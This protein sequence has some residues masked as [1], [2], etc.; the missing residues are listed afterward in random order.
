MKLLHYTLQWL[1]VKMSQLTLVTQTQAAATFILHSMQP[2]LKTPCVY[3]VGHQYEYDTNTVM[4]LLFHKVLEELTF[5]DSDCPDKISDENDSDNGESNRN[6]LEF[7]LEGDK[8]RR[9]FY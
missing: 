7:Q 1:Q 9:E 8:E 3:P 5:S 4:S 2:R 6:V